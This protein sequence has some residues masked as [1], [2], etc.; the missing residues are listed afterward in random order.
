MNRLSARKIVWSM[1]GILVAIAATLTPSALSRTV[2]LPNRSEPEQ[3]IIEQG[4]FRLHKFEQPIGEENYEISSDGESV[5]VKMDFLFTDR[6]TAVP[7]AASFQGS[8]DLTPAAFEIKGKSSR[9]SEMDAAVEVQAEKVRLRDR[10][11][12]TEAARPKQFFTIAGYAP[13][14]MQMLMVRYWASHGSPAELETLPSGR[15]KI[16]PRGQDTVS[17][18]G[19]NVT[20]D[21]YAVEGLIWGREALWFDSD[22][23]LVAAVTTDA[24]FDHFEAIRDGYEDALGA[25]VGRAGA[26]EM[27]ALAEI[28]KGI[29]GSRAETLA[30][31]GGTL[32]DGTG[33]ETIPDSAVVISKGRIFAAGPREKVKIPR[34]AKK[35]EVWGKTILPGLWDMHAHF[36]QVE[37]GPIYLAAGATTVRDCGNEFE[38][39]TAVRDSIAGGKGLGPRLLLA[40]V[41]DGTGPL[42]LGIERV[43][44][45]EQARMWVNRYHDAGFQQMKIYSSVK[46]EELK[47]VAEEAHR[48][49]MSVTGHIPD[50]LDAYQGVEAGMD[51]INHIPYI[52]DI[53]HPRLPLE[54]TDDELL[55]ADANVDLA[56]ADAQK[57][58]AFLVDHGTVLDPTLAIYEFLTAS[59]AKPTQSFEPGVVKV[60]PELARQLT[61]MGP[62]GPRTELHEKALVK[63]ISAVGAL[64]KAGVPIVAGTDQTVPGHSLHREIELYVQAGFTPMEA[65]Q[66]AT[67]VPARAM[68]LEKELGTIEVGKRADLIIV[69]GNPLESIRNIR[70]VE[71]VVTNG[72]MYNCAE[73]WR[74]VGFKP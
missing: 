29:S 53:M 17:V 34:G 59:T 2:R 4:K 45:V 5:S 26:D 52:L 40:G 64:H 58:I 43:D 50:G 33:L 10:E 12:W 68:G 65:I 14:T 46:W 42:S 60:A 73:L 72:V 63:A 21:H 47:A 69:N 35:V 3:K 20:L 36:E 30:L 49:G 44:T 66:A 22:R 1:L 74:S 70:K 8:R 19:K 15:V 24:E 9:D 16:E 41:V 27:A 7:I 39:I 61:D 37:W 48:L 25:L 55:Q 62:P 28:S 13:A 51:Q 67:I 11:K 71:Y 56:S 23:N 32:I 54:A 57:A 6:G 31:V 38:F 18:N